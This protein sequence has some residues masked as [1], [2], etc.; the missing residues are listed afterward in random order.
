[1]AD[2]KK[3]KPESKKIKIQK[4]KPSGYSSTDKLAEIAMDLL[5]G[6]RKP[7]NEA[8]K[9]LLKQMQEIKKKGGIVDIPFEFF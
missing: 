1:M 3:I 4:A 2:K 5:C 8:E 6:D 9:K 7:K